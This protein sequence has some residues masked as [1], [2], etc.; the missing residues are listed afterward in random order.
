MATREELIQ[1]FEFTVQQAKRT[2]SLYAEGEWDAAR[3][4]GWTPKQVYCHL[5]TLALAVPQLA[6]GLEGA[7]ESTD[8]TQGI[9][10]NQMNDQAVAAMAGMDPT[11]V[12]LA[13]EANYG[14]LIEFVKAMPDDQ[15]QA[16]RSFLSDPIPVSDILANSIMLHGIHHVYEASA[17][18]G[19]P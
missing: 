19:A 12:L 14:K 10:I 18:F 11:Q 1:G 9:D 2:T 17:R 5:A 13:F 3:A 8:I 6:Q 4:S 15:L 16:K 7:S